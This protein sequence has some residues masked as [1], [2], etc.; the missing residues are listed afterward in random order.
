MSTQPPFHCTG[1]NTADFTPGPPP[2][3]DSTTHGRRTAWHVIVLCLLDRSIMPFPPPPVPRQSL[4]SLF[5]GREH[6]TTLRPIGRKHR[7]HTHTTHMCDGQQHK[8]EKSAYIQHGPIARRTPRPALCI[9]VSVCVCVW[10][11]CAPLWFR[12]S[13]A[14]MVGQYNTRIYGEHGADRLQGV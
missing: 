14:E 8:S 1:H 9:C 2:R 12:P 6:A 5:Q 13:E 11:E 4:P 7:R 3:R 10:C